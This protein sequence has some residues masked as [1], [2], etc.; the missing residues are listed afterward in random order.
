MYSDPVVAATYG[1]NPAV[2]VIYAVKTKAVGTTP[3]T[4]HLFAHQVD[5]KSGELSDRIDLR[6]EEDNLINCS[7]ITNSMCSRNPTI[8]S[9]SRKSWKTTEK[10]TVNDDQ[11]EVE[12]GHKQIM[13]L[14]GGAKQAETLQTF[15]DSVSISKDSG[16]YQ[17]LNTTEVDVDDYHVFDTYVVK[18]SA[19]HLYSI[20]SNKEIVKILRTTARPATPTDA[21]CRACIG[22]ARISTCSIPPKA[23]T[24][25]SC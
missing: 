18:D 19:Y 25:T 1:P 11:R 6:T 3:E 22:S 15:K 5:L 12:I 10:R 17:S 14:S 8:A 13:G 20:D 9:P 2:F 23:I 21:T 24:A 16:G 4:V 7:R